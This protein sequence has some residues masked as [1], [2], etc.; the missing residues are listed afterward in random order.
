MFTDLLNC[1]FILFYFSLI[2][3]DNEREKKKGTQIWDEGYLVKLSIQ[4]N[5]SI[6]IS[7]NWNHKSK[8]EGIVKEQKKKE[9][10]KGH[11][12]LNMSSSSIPN[13]FSQVPP[14]LLPPPSSEQLCY[15]HC[16]ICDTVLAVNI[17]QLFGYSLGFVVVFVLIVN[18]CF[19]RWVFLV[20]VCSKGS[21]FVVAIAPIFCR[22]TCVVACFSLLQISFMALLTQPLT[23]SLPILTISW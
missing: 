13:T 23:F 10:K 6:K 19:I 15:V 22:W 18:L 17:L 21:P 12:L 20:V 8:R 9:K 4:S 3:V 1:S 14:P 5:Q 2:Y 16:N 7:T 11:K